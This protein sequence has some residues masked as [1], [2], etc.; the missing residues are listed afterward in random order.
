MDITPSRAA[1]VGAGEMEPGIALLFAR[2]GIDV[3]LIDRS[4]AQLDDPAG[5][6][7]RVTTSS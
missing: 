5:E 7:A 4:A 6:L 2:A 3:T 1:V